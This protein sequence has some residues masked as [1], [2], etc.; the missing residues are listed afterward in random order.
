MNADVRAL[1]RPWLG[2]R[3]FCSQVST[4]VR[5]N[6]ATLPSDSDAITKSGKSTRRCPL[7]AVTGTNPSDPKD[8]L[9]KLP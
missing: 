8:E 2:V 1:L 7:S 6:R 5:I 9:A 4:V 3:L